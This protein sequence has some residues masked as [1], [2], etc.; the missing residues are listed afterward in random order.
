MPMRGRDTYY[1]EHCIASCSLGMG[2]VISFVP[3]NP[4]VAHCWAFNAY[5][6]PWIFWAILW[7]SHAGITM[8]GC[9]WHNRRAIEW[10]G[11]LGA[12]LWFV[13]VWR[14][15]QDPPS[16][17]MACALSPTLLYANVR[18]FLYQLKISAYARSLA[19][20]GKP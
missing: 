4:M 19:D 3:P 15:F 20:A 16:Y 2:L 17:P 18:V 12:A 10:A 8:Y 11:L 14:A 5:N 1:L 7:L 9:I 6:V 13:F